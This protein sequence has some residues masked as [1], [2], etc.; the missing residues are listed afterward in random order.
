MNQKKILLLG[1]F[2]MLSSN[3]ATAKEPVTCLQKA[4]TQE[5][6]NDCADINLQQADG[7]L[8]RVYYALQQNYLKD[9]L[10]LKKLKEAQLAWIKLRDADFEM[11]F[12]H[13]KDKSHY[14]SSFPLC[15][16]NYKTQ[17]TLQRVAFLKE[18]LV[19]GVEGDVCNGSKQIPEQASVSKESIQQTCYVDFSGDPMKADTIELFLNMSSD[20]NKVTGEYNYLPYERDRRYGNIVGTIKDN[21]IEAKYTFEQEGEKDTVNLQIEIQDGKVIIKGEKKDEGL[22]VDGKLKKIDCEA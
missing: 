16:A 7:E 3:Y 9:K 15:A 22:G 1:M 5:A 13:A 10:F 17:L 12:P 4:M 6:M 21:V 2:F 18:W 8:N 20:N 11:K 14:G 19:G